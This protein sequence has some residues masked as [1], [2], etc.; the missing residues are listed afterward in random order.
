MAVLTYAEQLE[1]VQAAITKI[2]TTGQAYSRD[3]GGASV[4]HTRA[5]LKTLYQREQRLRV[6]VEREQRGGGIGVRP[7]TPI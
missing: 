3:S 6:L 2:E 4:A 5:D 7:V 1:A